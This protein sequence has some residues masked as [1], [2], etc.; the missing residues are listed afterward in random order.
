MP[1][2]LA[3]MVLAAATAGATAEHNVTGN[4]LFDA[5]NAAH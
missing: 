2:R 5:C 1:F 3:I 4:P